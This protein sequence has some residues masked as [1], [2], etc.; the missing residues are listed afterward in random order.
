MNEE[1]EFA[2]R[3]KAQTLNL[4]E[5][6]TRAEVIEC[7]DAIRNLRADLVALRGLADAWKI[8]LAGRAVNLDW[9]RSRLARLNVEDVGTGGSHV[10]PD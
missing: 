9:I 7:L 4:T 10:L 5:P 6:I 8:H 1:R 3:R 2:L